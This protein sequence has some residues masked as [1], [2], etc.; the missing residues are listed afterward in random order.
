MSICDYIF[1][2]SDTEAGCLTIQEALK[3]GKPVIIT[4]LPILEEFGINESNA[5]ILDF[6]MS[7]LDV[8]D[9][10]NIPIVKNWQEPISK[11]WEDIMKKKIYRERYYEEIDDIKNKVES[12]KTAKDKKKKSGK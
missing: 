11:E 4:K 12:T 7:N 8:E 2:G 3:I 1:Q 9:L 10:W 5:K 6:D